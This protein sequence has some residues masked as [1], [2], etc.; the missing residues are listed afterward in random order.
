[1]SLD[2]LMAAKE[3]FDDTYTAQDPLPYYES[4]AATRLSIVEYPAT[5]VRAMVDLGIARG[6]VVDLGCGYGTLGV[7]LRT[8][9]DIEGVYSAYLG[10]DAPHLP[11]RLDY[12][13]HIIG[14][15]KSLAALLAAQKA[16]FVSEGI[17]L[18]LDAS[19]L[20]IPDYGRDVIASCCAV[21]GYVQPV[22]LRIALDTLR[23]RVAIITCVTWLVA[24]L[25]QAFAGSDYEMTRLSDVPIFQRWATSG[26]ELRMP[27][28]LIQEAHRAHCFVLST[29]VVPATV[30]KERVECLRAQRAGNTWLAAGR[31]QGCELRRP[32]PKH[33]WNGDVCKV[34]S[35]RHYA[36]RL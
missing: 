11:E 2:T 24:E 17:A 29:D 26:E 32:W 19:P 30:L 8:G 7:L 35:T 10:G 14:V 6:P 31:S 27:D 23:P 25:C 36:A 15:D 21:L 1:M 5:L 18:D 16:G 13:P 22:A 4:Y 33:A 9:L 20:D 12:S 28:A 3:P 34:S